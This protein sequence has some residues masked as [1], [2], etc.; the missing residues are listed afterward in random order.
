MV[1]GASV[2]G[3]SA[4]AALLRSVIEGPGLDVEWYE[5]VEGR[6]SLVARIEGTDPSAPSLALMGHTD[7]VPADAADGW[8]H[9]PFGGELVDGEVWGR[10]AVDMLNQTAAMALAS[11]P[12]LTPAPAA[13]RCP[14]WCTA[15][16]RPTRSHTPF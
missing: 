16:T 11:P 8:T 1:D 14:P 3:A 10:G 9:D 12:T 7:V 5:P 15:G 13:P 4:N 2:G 6:A